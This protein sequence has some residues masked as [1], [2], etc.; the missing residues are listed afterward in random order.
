MITQPAGGM[1][2]QIAPLP[3]EGSVPDRG[4]APS[5]TQRLTRERSHHH[6]I[7]AYRLA[8][9]NIIT[10]RQRITPRSSFKMVFSM[11]CQRVCGGLHANCEA[12][13]SEYV[14]E[15]LVGLNERKERDTLDSCAHRNGPY[16]PRRPFEDMGRHLRC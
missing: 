12:I 14:V 3:R 5:A 9:D 13:H 4:S 1:W 6:D 10:P 8:I 7:A 11:V 15:I 2:C 16:I